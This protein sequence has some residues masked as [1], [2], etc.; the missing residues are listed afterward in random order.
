MLLVQL[1]TFIWFVLSWTVYVHFHV[2][3]ISSPSPEIISISATII[4]W[5]RREDHRSCSVFYCAHAHDQLRLQMTV[6]RDSHFVFCCTG[7]LTRSILFVLRLVSVFS[8]GCVS[9]A[10]D[11]R[12]TWLI[13]DVTCYMSNPGHSDSLVSIDTV[14]TRVIS[15][16]LFSSEL[17]LINFSITSRRQLFAV[18]RHVS[19]VTLDVCCVTFLHTAQTT[20]CTHNTGHAHT[21]C[22]CIQSALCCMPYS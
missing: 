12:E 22:V 10:A 2:C 20:V 4:V 8:V 21:V 19:W 11:C 17:L 16:I 1:V 14:Y 3:T 5:R 15:V 6:G 7:F 9:Y 18:T 13:T